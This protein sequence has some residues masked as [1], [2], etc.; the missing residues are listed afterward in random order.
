MNIFVVDTN[1]TIAAQQLCDKHIIKMITESVQMLSWAMISVGLEGPYKK[2]R[3]WNHPCSKWTR[4]S[5]ANYIWLYNHADEIGN[6]YSRRYGKYHLAH[7]KLHN[8]IEREIGLPNTGLTEFANCTPYKEMNNIVE[9]YRKFYI[10]EKSRFAK[11][12]KGTPI[13]YWYKDK[14]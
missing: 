1:P 12:N 6:E 5:L 14:V 8:K 7:W 11:W 13:P 4:A 3:H 2:D 10:E 9:A